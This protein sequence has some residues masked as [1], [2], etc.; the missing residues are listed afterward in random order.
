MGPVKT[1]SAALPYVVGELAT[2]A[3]DSR[4]LSFSMRDVRR[5]IQALDWFISS[6]G[7]AM[8]DAGLDREIARYEDLLYRFMGVP[9][10]GMREYVKARAKDAQG[11]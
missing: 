7:E 1:P 8:T 3:Y 10:D 9:E 11:R 2:D 4:V 5:C 6:H